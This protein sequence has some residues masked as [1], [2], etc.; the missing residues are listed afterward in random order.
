MLA[1]L[2]SISAPTLVCAG[3][4][5]GIAPVVNSEAIVAGIK[6]S[7]LEMFEGGPSLHAARPQVAL[8]DARLS[9][10]IS[11]RCG[12]T[13]QFARFDLRDCLTRALLAATC[14]TL[15]SLCGTAGHALSVAVFG[16]IFGVL[17]LCGVTVA[18]G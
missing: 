6:D 10:G 9:Y 16:F 14:R 11:G 1:D 5:D 17:V 12:L 15:V 18:T 3:R 4:Y 13:A 2:G 8:G 7:R